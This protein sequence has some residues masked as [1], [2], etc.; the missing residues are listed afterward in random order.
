VPGTYTVALTAN[1]KTYTQPLTVEMD[2]RVKTP[3]ADL[4]QQFALSKEMY[5]DIV[6]LE[7]ISGRVRAFR[8]Q[9]RAAIASADISA[10]RKQAT[11]LAGASAEEDDEA[12]P[13]AAPDHETLSSLTQSLRAVLRVLQESDAAPTTQTRRRR[14]RPT[15]RVSELLNRAQTFE[16]AYAPRNCPQP[17][18]DPAPSSPMKTTLG[19][20]ARRRTRQSSPALGADWRRCA[21]SRR[22]SIL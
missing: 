21:I 9:M 17:R 2:P 15:P 6:Q 16:T 10:L 5:D 11:E 3:A 4:Q 8:A 18:K 1:G 20:S 13:V 7:E 22:A 14:R 12:P 19:R